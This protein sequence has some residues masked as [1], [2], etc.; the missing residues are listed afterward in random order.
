MKPNIHP[1]YKEAAVKCASCGT[2]YN[3]KSTRGNMTV[4]ICSACHPF[5]TGTERMIDA[6]GRVDRFK[7]K[8]KLK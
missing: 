4:D 3:M 1:E 8:Y 7:K 5:F 6:A 2:V